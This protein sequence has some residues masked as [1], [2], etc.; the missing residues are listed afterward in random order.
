MSKNSVLEDGME[1][2]PQKAPLPCYGLEHDRFDTTCQACPHAEG[3][4]QKMGVRYDMVPLT[5]VKWNLV[6]ETFAGEA[7]QMDDPEIPHIKRIYAECY[8]SVFHRR[9]E[10]H[11]DYRAAKTVVMNS[12]RVPCS[13]RMFI[14]SNMV[15]QR[16]HERQTIQHTSKMV[17]TKFT[18]KML[19]GPLAVKRAKA[20]QEMCHNEFGTFTLKSL[21]VLTD[22]DVNELA[23]KDDMPAR[24]LRSEVTAAQWLVRYKIF[25]GG[26]GEL[27][28]YQSVEL[29]LDP[30]WLAIEQTYINLILKPYIDRKLKGSEAEERHR[31]NVFQ[32]HGW[33]KRHLSDQRVAFLAR[34][35]I[36]PEAV[37][38][39]LSNF[40]HDTNDF[41]Y[42]RPPETDPMKFWL[43]LALTIRHYHCWLYLHGENSYF[44]PRAER[45]GHRSSTH[46]V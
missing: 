8:E 3:C 9:H 30:A 34:Q 38:R 33:Y 46:D 20:Y 43:R 14:L 41:L 23:I 5:K 27:A 36:M 45:R 1:R 15:A 35:Q 17:P 28:M 44:T 24:M 40:S 25:N 19:S 39:V 42:P 6:P 7:L 12:L 21:S 4:V 11:P 31:F 16:E 32:T 22:D 2:I 29:Q 26:S 37:A 18:F 10:T 13:L